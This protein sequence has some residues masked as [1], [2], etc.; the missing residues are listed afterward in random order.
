MR[1]L[2]NKKKY[3]NSYDKHEIGEQMDGKAAS[4]RKKKFLALCLNMVLKELTN[5]HLHFQGNESCKYNSCSF[6]VKTLNQFLRKD[7]PDHEWT[8]HKSTIYTVKQGSLKKDRTHV[9]SIKGHVN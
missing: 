7:Y 4:A 8:N 1:T 6:L 5:L 3:T 2:T 9:L